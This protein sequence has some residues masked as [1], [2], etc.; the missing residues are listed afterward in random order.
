MSKKKFII[1]LGATGGHIFPGIA[2]ADAIKELVLNPNL[3]KEMGKK[4]RKMAENRFDEKNV[5]SKHLEI[6]NQ[7][8]K[9]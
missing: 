9:H 2:L 4:G 1:C 6:Y 3:Y 5:I 7:L 8:L